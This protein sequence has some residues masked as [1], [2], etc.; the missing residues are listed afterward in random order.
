MLVAL[1][2][3]FAR[4]VAGVIAGR[5]DMCRMCFDSC[6]EI[7]PKWFDEPNYGKPGPEL[8]LRPARASSGVTS[9]A[10]LVVKIKRK[11]P[12]HPPQPVEFLLAGRR[13]RSDVTLFDELLGQAAETT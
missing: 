6:G 13:R 12:Q 8:N 7:P 11:S 2:A 10:M 5:L 4:G 9:L 1:G 3:G